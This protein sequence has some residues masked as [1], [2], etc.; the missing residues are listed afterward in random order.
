VPAKG[1]QSIYV[2]DR[3]DIVSPTLIW[4]GAKLE[5]KQENI[6]RKR[7]FSRGFIKSRVK[8]SL[9]FMTKLLKSAGFFNNS[10]QGVEEL[11]GLY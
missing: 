6:S 2:T 11:I 10:V 3:N 5:A 9:A 7:I 8:F 1:G 4:A